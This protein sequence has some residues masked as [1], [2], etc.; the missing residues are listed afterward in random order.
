MRRALER[1]RWFAVFVVLALLIAACT[2]RPI[3]GPTGWKIFGPEGPRGPEGP[4]GPPGPPGP[5]GPLGAQGPPGPEGP[6]GPAGVAGAQGPAGPAGAQGPVTAAT[7]QP[8][9]SPETKWITFDDVLF[10][11]DKSEIR[12]SEK[13]KIDAVVE[14]M[15]QNPEI[16]LGI[17]GHADPRGSDRYN[18]ALSQRRSEAVRAA[19]VRAG[20]PANRIRTGAHGATQRKCNEAT[21]ECWQL[22]RRV[23]VLVSGS[24]VQPAASPK[25]PSR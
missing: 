10:D 22:D 21:E 3:G 13:A 1:G 25:E 8:S 5:P 14:H 16:I 24:A 9:A 19:L 18:Q 6:A 4:A 2:A 23:E 17:A 11:F 15:K 7:V 20:I 12:P